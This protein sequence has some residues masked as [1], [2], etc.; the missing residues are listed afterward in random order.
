M[1]HNADKSTCVGT[2]ADSLAQAVASVLRA[3]S[4]T[5][6]DVHCSSHSSAVTHNVNKTECSCTCNARFAGATCDECAA[7]FAGYPNCTECTVIDHCNGHTG[8]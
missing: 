4:V 3:T 1:T 7:G 2:C 5:T 8:A 6:D